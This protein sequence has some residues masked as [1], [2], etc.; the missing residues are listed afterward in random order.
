MNDHDKL[1]DVNQ[2]ILTLPCFAIDMVGLVITNLHLPSEPTFI[3]TL[4][5]YSSIDYDYHDLCLAESI[6]LLPKVWKIS[7][8]PS[9]REMSAGNLSSAVVYVCLSLLLSCPGYSP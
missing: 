9:G 7:M 5:Y 1:S 6:H 3:L 4:C 2:H 8:K